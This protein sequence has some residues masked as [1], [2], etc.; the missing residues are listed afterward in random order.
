MLEEIDIKN[1]DLNINT[2]K[3]LDNSS[4]DITID[5]YRIY[6]GVLTALEIETLYDMG[7]P[8]ISSV[9]IASDNTTITVTFNKSVY[10][11][12]SGSGDLEAADF[13]LSISG[14]SADLSSATPTSISKTSQTVW[15]LGIGLSGTA[16]GSETLTINP[17]SNSIYNAGGNAA[18]TSQ[19]NNTGSLNSSG[20]SSGKVTVNNTFKITIS[21][22]GKLTVSS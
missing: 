1:R 20:S 14:G 10:N 7:F 13:A 15:V 21:S 4:R 11:T 17:A 3:N 5:D 19:S 18:S 6:D 8:S 2:T 22:T 12:N 9:S 16:N